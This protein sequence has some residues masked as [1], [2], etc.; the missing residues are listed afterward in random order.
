MPAMPVAQSSEARADLVI[1]ATAEPRGI[2]LG[3]IVT[4]PG[5]IL[6]ALGLTSSVPTAV[7]LGTAVYVVVLVFARLEHAAHDDAPSHRA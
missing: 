7:L 4:L 2:W 1:Y 6:L 3:T 5:W